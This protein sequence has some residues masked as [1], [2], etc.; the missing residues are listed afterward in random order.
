MNKF[1][2]SNPEIMSGVPCIAGTRLPLE[3][4]LFLLKEGYTLHDVH[5]EYPHVSLDTFKNVLSELA[6]T[7]NT[8]A[9]DSK[10]LQIQT[11]LR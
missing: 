6:L 4:V 8:H 2:V 5:D 7:L 11:A 1:I 3:R 9:H 10:N